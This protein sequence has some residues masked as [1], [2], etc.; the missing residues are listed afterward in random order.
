MF[1]ISTGFLTV[2]KFLISSLPL[3]VERIQN[4]SKLSEI[5]REGF[6]AVLNFGE[7]NAIKPTVVMGE[8]QKASTSPDL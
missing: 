8:K 3:E 4:H 5:P 7:E 6:S 2:W 1:T